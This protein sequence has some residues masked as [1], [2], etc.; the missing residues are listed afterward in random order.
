M[1]KAVLLS[2]LTALL[3]VIVSG[4]VGC[5]PTI[6]YDEAEVRAFAD[7]ATE[8]T[9]QGLSEGDLAKYT[10]Y[11][12]AGFKKAVTQEIMDTM[13]PQIE[14]R[15]GTY[16]SK[17]FSKVTGQDNYILVYYKAKYT[18]TDVTIRMVF[19][20]DHLVAGQWFE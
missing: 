7:P 16:V 20:Q 14:D 11:G 4:L 17:E 9:L 18:K 15:F 5:A 10:E 13:V 2:L 6:T 19:D 8:I 12:N 1:K 3:V